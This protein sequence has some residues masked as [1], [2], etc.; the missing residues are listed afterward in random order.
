M[1]TELLIT[2]EQYAE[3]LCDDLDLNPTL[4]LPAIS[5]AIR[6]QIDAYP[7]DNILEE[8]ADQRAILKVSVLNA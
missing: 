6:S 2:P 8:A 4:F 7:V 5:Q 3:V 1:F